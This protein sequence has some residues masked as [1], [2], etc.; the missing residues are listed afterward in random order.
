MK[1]LKTS[2]LFAALRVMKQANVRDELK[3]IFE[4]AKQDNAD[5][6]SVGMDGIL[7]IVGALTEKKAEKA[8]F[9]FLAGPFEVK[10]SEV[11]EMPITELIEN[12]KHLAKE[13]D[14]T[15]FFTSIFGMIGKN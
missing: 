4:K 12:L 10:P 2:D 13:N 8:M 1:K 14:L 15:D 6:Q 9:E 3:P 5:V 7:A 11:E